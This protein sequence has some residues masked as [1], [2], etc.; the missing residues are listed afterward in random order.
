M[1]LI[2]HLHRLRCCWNAIFFVIVGECV[3]LA[4]WLVGWL[5]GWLAH[6]NPQFLT[7]YSLCVLVSDRSEKESSV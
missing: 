7:K 4:G 6:P 1:N 2:H 3:T 5:A